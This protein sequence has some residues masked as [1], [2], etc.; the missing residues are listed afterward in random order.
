MTEESGLDAGND[1]YHF[2][3]AWADYDGDGWIDL[4]VAN[5]FGTKNLY[6]NRGRQD[7]TVTFEDVAAA[8]GVL[9]HGAGMSAAFVD[10]DNDGLLDIYTGN[11]WSASGL[12]VTVGAHLHARR[13]GRCSRAHNLDGVNFCFFYLL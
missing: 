8:A 13:A 12:R 9:D 11:M 6:R 5:D 2:A 10:Y 4:L 1:R 7:G 3:A